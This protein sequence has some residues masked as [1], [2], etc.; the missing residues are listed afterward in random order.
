VGN[1]NQSE[2]GGA[3]NYYYNRHI[4]KIQADF[5]QLKDEAANSG[6]GTKNKE[7]RLQAQFIF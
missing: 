4:M 6:R 1:N 5:R 3:V 7:F 2:I